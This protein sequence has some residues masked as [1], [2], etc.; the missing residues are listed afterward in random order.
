MPKH[1]LF[2]CFIAAASLAASSGIAARAAEVCAGFKWDV[3]H[4]HALFLGTAQALGAGAS[5]AAAPAIELDRLYDLTLQPQDTVQFAAPVGKKMLTDGGYG[6]LVRFRVPADGSYRV[7]VNI[8]FWLDVVGD[9]KTLTSTDFNGSA[10]CDTPR[11]IVVYPLTAGRELLLQL[12]GE[13]SQHVRVTI[14]AV[15][16]AP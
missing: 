12:S 3:K 5:A 16:A 11:K 9:G 2:A 14:T 10:G 1:R 4:E 7:A 8:A 6:G 15:P 13:V